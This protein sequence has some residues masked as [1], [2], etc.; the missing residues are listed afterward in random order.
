MKE[1]KIDL[2]KKLN[3]TDLEFIDNPIIY[4][5]KAFNSAYSEY[6]PGDTITI[7]CRADEEPS[8]FTSAIHQLIVEELSFVNEKKLSGLSPDSASLRTLTF[9]LGD[10]LATAYFKFVQAKGKEL[11]TNAKSYL[12][13]IE[14]GEFSRIGTNFSFK[15]T[16]ADIEQGFNSTSSPN[17]VTFS[18]STTTSGT[19]SS[20]SSNSKTTQETG[21]KP[22]KK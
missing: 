3:I 10:K 17:P 16:K 4:F 18:T 5:R 6:S 12:Q 15:N 19:T 1:I 22:K 8:D 9:G 11:S 21:N 13:C 7:K 20:N 14:K 2:L